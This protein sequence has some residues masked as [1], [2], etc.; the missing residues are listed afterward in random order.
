[1]APRNVAS[2]PKMTSGSAQ[3]VRILLRRHPIVRPGIAAGVKKGMI[4]SASEKR[5]WMAPL[6]RSNPAAT[7]VSAV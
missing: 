4:V 5:T 3:P 6:A 2:E 7:I 1:M